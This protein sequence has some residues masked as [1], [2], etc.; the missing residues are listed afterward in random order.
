MLPDTHS[1]D[2]VSEHSIYLQKRFRSPETPY[3]TC[4]WV[5]KTSQYTKFIDPGTS[6]VLRLKGPLGC[7][8][9]VL[10]ASIIHQIQ[11]PRPGEKTPRVLYCYARRDF[12]QT[13]SNTLIRLLLWQILE[14]ATPDMLVEIK[15]IHGKHE[16]SNK[17]DASL[18]ED[19]WE[20]LANVLAIAD[21]KVII[22]VD[23]FDDIAQPLLCARLLIKAVTTLADSCRC[24]LL[25][26]SR[27]DR[28]DVFGNKTIRLALKRANVESLQLEMSHES[29]R[30]DLAAY[31]SYQVKNGPSFLS[32]SEIIQDRIIAAVCER[33][34]GM[35]LYANLVLDD[36]K[37]AAIS[38]LAD[39]QTTLQNLPQDLVNSYQNN[40]QNLRQTRRG[41]E[42]IRWILCSNQ[43]LSWNEL[44]S[45]LAIGVSRYMED[46]LI[47]DGCEAFVE[48]SCGQM[49]E[50]FGPCEHMRFVHPTVKDFLIDS[51]EFGDGIDISRA[52]A[53]VAGKLL[54]FL[55]YPDLPSFFSSDVESPE[56]V[57]KVYSARPGRALYSF[58]TF[59]WYKHLRESDKSENVHLE[60]QVIGFLKSPSFVRWLKS[61]TIMS[62]V[63][64]DGRD[65]VSLTADVIDSLQEFVL[66]RV[67]AFDDSETMI[68]TWIGH[69]LDLMLD[70]GT[71]IETQPDWIH[72][73]HQQFL[74]EAS[75][76]RS[77]LED[78]GDQSIVQFCAEP[79]F[80][81]HSERI[82]W[83]SRCFA[84]DVTKDLAFTYDE[85]YISCYH[86]KTGLLAAEIAISAPPNVQGALEVK[87]GALSPCGKYLAVAFEAM[88]PSNDP[89]GSQIRAGRR[90]L[91]NTS[92]TGF[93]W[94][95]DHALVR[96]ELSGLL[97][98]MAI[99]VDHA[100]FVVC[101]LELRHTGLARTHLFGLPS[102]APSPILSTGTATMRWDLDDVDVLQFSADSSQL[103]TSFGIFEL[104]TGKV[105]KPW[106][107]ALNH[108]YQGGKLTND[109]SLFG[110]VL[111]DIEGDCIVQLYDMDNKPQYR[112]IRFPGVVHI[113][114]ISNHG[115][116]LLLTRRDI[117]EQ[118][119]RTKAG[120][121]NRP[122][123]QGTIGV[124]DCRDGEWTP[125]LVLDQDFTDKLPQ[126]S[127]QTFAYSPTFGPEA[128]GENELNRVFLY[129]PSRWKLASSVRKVKSLDPGQDHLLLFECKRS[130]KG[131]GKN[132]SLKLDLLAAAFTSVIRLTGR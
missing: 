59:S 119:K 89:V 114:A 7:G 79:I 42:T 118:N 78:D 74:S 30:Q 44:K 83:P 4:D 86:I 45:A 24:S 101:L 116:F 125:L 107:F 35:F 76:F 127:L 14:E 123:Q 126:W 82:T 71:V 73:L 100:E 25:L 115:R 29:I 69:F 122:V 129:V 131:F 124:W 55:D 110:T 51:K 19:L 108:F 56:S 104:E 58:A 23:G 52:H 1:P 109:F 26:S 53:M 57:I 49:V 43:A 32:T 94:G 9:S 16:T 113:L 18:E 50:S 84:I 64:E 92:D 38:S 102:W 67:W 46:E 41:L 111:R 98:H 60:K 10:T 28:L 117:V 2:S 70:W 77:L 21:E 85:P 65:S 99:G 13:S 15:K 17:R 27:L 97:A 128:E 106:S 47:L 40:F 130:A 93:Q 12:G 31:V 54:V 20:L 105:T 103:A 22:V 132:P 68:Q 3:T 34:N 6:S 8:K 80:T 62:R 91:L 95:M 48:H 66:G 33:S 112:E 96:I 90:L 87:R 63:S 39:I 5:F 11:S 88:G 61:A 121:T 36:L 37:D 120:K 81:K 72:Y 75:Y